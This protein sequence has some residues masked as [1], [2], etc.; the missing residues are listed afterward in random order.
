M[1][2]KRRVNAKSVFDSREELLTKPTGFRDFAEKNFTYILIAV[3]AVVVIIIGSFVWG[4]LDNKRETTAAEQL[5]QSVALYEEVVSEDGSIETALERFQT[6]SR[7]YG[8]TSSGVLSL[9]Y[10]GNCYYA[11]QDY[12]EAIA[13]YERFLKAAPRDTHLRIL[14]YDSLGYCF[15]EKGE[16]EKAIEYFEKTIDPAPGLGETAFLNLA[17]CY[18]ALED[19]E[20]S[21]KY[22][23]RVMLEYPQSPKAIYVQEKINILENKNGRGDVSAVSDG[24]DEVSEEPLEQ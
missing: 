4:Y 5:S 23:Q 19:A 21:L 18:E 8:G 14:A 7:K 3:V 1:V 10:A 15:E 16:Y 13:R 11:L 20:N 22:Y 2:R 6:I 24:T 17:R 12:D 9:F